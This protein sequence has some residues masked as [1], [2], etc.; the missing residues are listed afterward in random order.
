MKYAYV[1]AAGIAFALAA[2]AIGA[3]EKKDQTEEKEKKICRTERAT[4]SLISKRRICKTQ[5]EWD[6]L[7]AETKKQIDEY[8]SRMG[9]R[10]GAGQAGGT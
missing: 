3:D 9:N 1:V 2:P 7:A 10:E 4:G 5:A 8:G 6:Q